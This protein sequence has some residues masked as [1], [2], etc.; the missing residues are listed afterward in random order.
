MR[1]GVLTPGSTPTALLLPREGV[2]VTESINQIESNMF[3][4]LRS[5]GTICPSIVPKIIMV[6]I[7]CGLSHGVVV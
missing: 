5:T 1:E 4:D 3:V 7:W 6:V 2:S